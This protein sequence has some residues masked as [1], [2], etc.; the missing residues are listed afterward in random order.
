MRARRPADALP[1]IHLET[2][3]SRTTSE[4]PSETDCPSLQRISFTVPGSSAS[5][6]ISIFIDSRITTV[7]PSCTV[8][9]T[10]TSIFQTVPVMC[11][12]TSGKCPPARFWLQEAIRS[13]SG[14]GY[15]AP[16]SYNCTA[17]RLTKPRWVGPDPLLAVKPRDRFH[18]VPVELEV[19]DLR[20]LLDPG[21]AH[22]PR[23]HHAT[24]LDVPAQQYL[25][26]RA[27]CLRR[28]VVD[29]LVVQ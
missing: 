7:S 24:E 19:E 27:A 9:P 12:R 10:S 6:G 3:Y 13:A 23:D 20:V 14:G 29:N 25:R 16:G 15:A 11:A 22:R 8:S 28:D 18:L 21:R 1:S 26:R 17:E 5:T 2:G 4:S